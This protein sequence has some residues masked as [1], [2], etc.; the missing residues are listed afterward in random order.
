M[1]GDSHTAQEKALE[2]NVD[3]VKH[4]TFAEIG[5]GQEVARWFFH[6]GKASATI[7]RSISAYDMAISDSLYGPTPHYVSR[8]RLAAMLDRE[9][10]QLVK[11]LNET[12]GDQN[13]F[14]VFADTVATHGS[15]RS[16]GGH[17]WLGIRF[18]DQPRA[19]P[20]EV[21]IHIEMLDAFTASQQEAVGLVGVNLIYGAFN[22][23][24]NPPLLI[25]R[26]MDG[27]DR[28]RVEIDMVK[29]SGP[30]FSSP[31]NRLMSLQLVEQGLTDAAM[32]T[33]DGEV[34][35]PSEVLHDRPVVIERGSFRPVTNVTLAMLDG[36]LRDLRLEPE[37]PPDAPV[38]VMEMTLNNLMT[39]RSID[40]QDFLA[41][42]DL[43]GALDKMVMISSYTR[44]DC[45]TTYLR[46]Y[47]KNW[48]GFVAGVPTLR[49]IVDEQYYGDLQGGILEG[50]G[51]LFRDRVK[52]FAYPTVSPAT[53]ELETADKLAISSKLEH[54]YAHLLENGF[55]EPVQEF[56]AEQLHISPGEVLR[57]IQ[58][59]D[60]AWM[61][62][63]PPPAAALIQRNELFGLKGGGPRQDPQEAKDSP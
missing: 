25:R 42:A 37:G 24:Q 56:D 8:L 39:G 3:G 55:I 18:Q 58:S 53:G 14:F 6:V 28:R 59:G 20:S 19:V 27:L 52:L 2:I 9:Y 11:Q 50:L 33:A 62:F 46:E 23:H 4:G 13:A 10:D 17:G 30:V 40:H 43:L 51:R 34:V 1:K 21:I 36:A 22:L 35:Q 44:F 7:A 16:S 12:R 54:L 31:D 41:R 5:A 60:P 29:L 63:V 26:L 61:D 15:A 45:V 38:V 32:F 48:I 47:T 57:K 49:A